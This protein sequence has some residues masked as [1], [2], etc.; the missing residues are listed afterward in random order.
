MD[1]SNPDAATHR[2]IAVLVVDRVSLIDVAAL[3]ERLADPGRNACVN[4]IL[5]CSP[6]GQD[7]TTRGGPPLRVAADAHDAG[8]TDTVIALGGNHLLRHNPVRVHVVPPA[9]SPHGRA[10]WPAPDPASSS[11]A[12]PDCCAD[13]GPPHAGSTPLS[14]RN[15][16]RRPS[17]TPAQRSAR[18][19][20]C[21]PRR[22]RTPQGRVRV[23]ARPSR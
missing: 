9:A 10:D 6:G 11:S 12:P 2:R 7:T 19:A 23:P 18:T 16:T 4:D 14:R 21:S 22:A 15:R 5:V 1:R 17:S 20:T 13:A 8:P 3:S